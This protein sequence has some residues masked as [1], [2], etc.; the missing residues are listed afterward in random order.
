M[1]KRLLL[2]LIIPLFLSAKAFATHIVGGEFELRHTSNYN[3]RLF[4]NLYFDKVNGLPLAKDQN[5]YVAIFE[6]GTN[7]QIRSIMLPLRSETPMSYTNVGCSTSDLKTDK[8]QYYEDLYLDPAIYNNPT[9]YYVVWERC[10][11]NN[12]ITNIQSP[13][14]SGTTF[15]M[16]FPPVIKNGVFF[17]NSSPRLS[18]PPND[19]AC[20][21]E[22]FYYNFGSTDPDGDVLV[23]D[24]VTPLNGY[25]SPGNVIP[26]P[27]S[28]PYP[29]IQWLPGYSKDNQIQGT[30]PVNI[31]AT[32]GRLTV[33]PGFVGLYVFGVR[34][35]EFRNGEKIGE[36]RRD[37]QLLVKACSR[38]ETPEI[39]TLTPGTNTT[40]VEGQVIRISATDPRCFKVYFTDPDQ[41]EPLSLSAVPVN[42]SNSFFNLS[43]T[44]NGIVNTVGGEKV[45]EATLCLEKCFDTNGETFLLD[46]IAS[47]NGDNGCGLPKQA[48]IRLSLVVEPQEDQPP[49][50]SFSTPKRIIEVEAGDVVSFDVLGMDPDDEEVTI[51][52]V[53]KGFDLSTQNISFETKTGMGNVSSPFSWQID[54]EA[55]NQPTYQIE[56]TASSSCGDDIFQKEIVE[57]RTIRY[58]IVNNTV[59]GEQ[60]I[61]S[62]QVP[63]ALSGTLPTGGKATLPYQYTWE[64]SST[65]QNSGFTTAPGSSD[66]Q[67]Y[68]PPALFK[69]TWFRRRVTSGLCSAHVSEPIKVVVNEAIANNTVSGNQ[70]ICINSTPALLAGSNPTGGNSTYAY[71]WEYSQ[72]SE[73]SG[74]KPANGINNTQ[75]YQPEALSQT[76]W[77]RRVA[78]SSTCDALTSQAVKIT[79]VPA[80][81]QNNI[82]GAQLVCFGNAPTE[83]TG[84]VPGGGTGS[85]SYRWEYSTESAAT[86]FIPAP[87]TNTNAVY[88]PGPLKQSTWFRR[89]VTS[90][91]CESISNAVFI[92]VDPLPQ[93]PLTEGAVICPDEMAILKATPKVSGHVLQWY[94]QAT[95][96]NLV[97]TGKVFTTPALQVTTDYFVQTVNSNGCVSTLRTKVTATV[98]PPTADAGQDK[99]I[100]EGSY[101]ALRAKGGVSYTWSPAGSVSNPNIPNP[102]AR[103]QQ[104]T[105]YTVSV[106]SE[107]G[108]IYTDEVTVTVLP[109]IA[110]TNALTVNGDGA[111]DTWAIRNIEY[112]PNCRVQVFT[113]W[114]ARIFDSRGYTQPWDGT[115]NGSP[116]PMAAYYF[117][118]DLGMGTE[119]VAGS[120]T[121]IK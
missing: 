104:T 55:I 109:R 116:L 4:F 54:C 108:C 7:R 96:G 34:C 82:S 76:T 26:P 43:G 42:F 51:S 46:L 99:T 35:Q 87:G 6:Q 9:G 48:I 10:C 74:F 28:A 47:D 86:G 83:L 69:T 71:L 1:N 63:S 118:I 2:L 95:G 106:V 14:A 38:N 112:Y 100:I 3:Y 114:G 88:I 70:T 23:Y 36:V 89:V 65:N 72:Q 119:P 40:Y 111:N 18:P 22:L 120:V 20:V 52:A 31:D 30:P 62:G 32:T 93:S 17:Q 33:K 78:M 37:F 61:C 11:R 44:T 102:I 15:Y 80:V 25:S 85:F 24:I 66:Q 103:P 94:D 56:F 77:Y 12:T 113:K 107:L 91:P 57:F 98:M 19:Y 117:L 13:D 59:T 64:M 45:L 90:T 105:T 27:S 81:T 53:G 92:T 110:P 67:N 5:V 73:N 68:S 21:D 115:H 49:V 8:I 41:D 50:I 97:Y 58:D 101:A 79:I 121:L 16:E 75:N 39:S 60:T 84:I 29:E